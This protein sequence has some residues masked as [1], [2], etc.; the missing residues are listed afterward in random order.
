MGISNDIEIATIAQVDE[1]TMV[2]IKATI[3]L[4]FQ[5]CKFDSSALVVQW[6]QKSL[7]NSVLHVQ[8]F[9]VIIN[10]PLF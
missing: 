8:C 4:P 7:P 3:A 6:R 10:L 1:A 5:F 2:K 9:A